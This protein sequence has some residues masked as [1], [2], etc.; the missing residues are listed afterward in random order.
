MGRDW[1]ALDYMEWRDTALTLQL[2]SQ[3][4]GKIRIALVPWRNHSWQVPFYVTARGLGSSG[5]LTG[6]EMI[7]IEFDFVDH[8][9]VCRS[10]N[11]KSRHVTLLPIS[12]AVILW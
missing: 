11:G 4:V 9:L 10:S 7:D 2:W 1:P 6:K 3:I 12:V 8:R 5:I